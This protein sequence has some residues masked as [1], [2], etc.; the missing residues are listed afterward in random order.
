MYTGVI[1]VNVHFSE[2]SIL[3]IHWIFTGVPAKKMLGATEQDGDGP[4]YL[5][6]T[7]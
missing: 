3:G 5:L 4:L 7:Q 1:H 6:P 2:E